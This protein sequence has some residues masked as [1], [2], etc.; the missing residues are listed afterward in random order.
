MVKTRFLRNSRRMTLSTGIGGE[1]IFPP[2]LSKNAEKHGEN[3]KMP[4]RAVFAPPRR[5]PRKRG[6]WTPPFWDYVSPHFV[7]WRVAR[8]LRRKVSG[9]FLFSVGEEAFFSAP[10]GPHISH[11]R[12]FSM[13]QV[14]FRLQGQRPNWIA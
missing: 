8:T 14:F 4:N 13:P 7:R 1:L 9:P 3:A 5:A 12:L 2:N 6:R 10:S 11:A